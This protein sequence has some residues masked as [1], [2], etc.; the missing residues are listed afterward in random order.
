MSTILKETDTY[1]IIVPEC[2]V[3]SRPRLFCSVC[4]YVLKTHL[5][6]TANEKYEC[7]HDC[8]L[9]FAEARKDEWLQGWRPKKEVLD[10]IRIEKD[11]IFIN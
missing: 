4:K 2:F 11:R 10:S 8:F 6:E 7:C 5:D 3:E 9:R 1:V